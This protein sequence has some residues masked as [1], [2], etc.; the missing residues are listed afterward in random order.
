MHSPNIRHQVSNI[1][2][3]AVEDHIITYCLCEKCDTAQAETAILV[4]GELRPYC[5]ECAKQRIDKALFMRAND[6]TMM[7]GFPH[8]PQC[9]EC[10]VITGTGTAVCP[11]E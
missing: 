11:S 2:E 3:F 4:G 7:A 9:G 10:M 6:I 1:L 8:C 5:L